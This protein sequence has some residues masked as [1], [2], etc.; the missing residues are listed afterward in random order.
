MQAMALSAALPASDSNFPCFGIMVRL[1]GFVVLYFV[2]ISVYIYI[3][4]YIYIALLTACGAVFLFYLKT[5]NLVFFLVYSCGVILL[6]V[7]YITY[8]WLSI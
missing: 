1:V 2:G 6:I 7:G 5:G 3:Y 4:I 8:I